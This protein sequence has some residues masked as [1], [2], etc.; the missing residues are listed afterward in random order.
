MT[1]HGNPPPVGWILYDDSCGLCRHWVPLLENALRRRGYA[2]A[3]LQ[4]DWVREKLGLD[5]ACLLDDLRLLL[6]D[7]SQLA[8][9]DAYR[10]AMRRIWWALPFYLFAIAPGLRLL[11]DWAY[12]R[13]AANRHRLSAACHFPRR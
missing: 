6:A 1:P 9:A 13:L 7:G 11:F 8:G 10:H 4:A 12:R 2:V 3:P 5:P